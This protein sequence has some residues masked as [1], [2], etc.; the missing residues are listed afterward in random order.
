M[1]IVRFNSWTLS[2]VSAEHYAQYRVGYIIVTATHIPFSPNL[3]RILRNKECTKI[4]SRWA[5]CGDYKNLFRG[6]FDQRQRHV[7]GNLC[8]QTKAI[9]YT[10]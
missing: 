4:I 1:D 9:M 3:V 5:I 2:G 10:G 8:R 7:G 6:E